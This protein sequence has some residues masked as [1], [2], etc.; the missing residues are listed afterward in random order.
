M[1]SEQSIEAA[2]QE[3]AWEVIESDL[4]F[5]ELLGLLGEPAAAAV[6]LS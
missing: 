1:S 2:A 3:R 5:G 4:A 6:E